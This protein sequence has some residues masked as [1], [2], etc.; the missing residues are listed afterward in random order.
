MSESARKRPAYKDLYKIPEN[1]TGEI[2][3][4]ELVVTPRP[5]RKH[6]YSTTALGAAVVPSYQFG[7]GGGLGGWVIIIEPEIGFGENIMV[8]DIAGWKED[9]YPEEEPHN[10]ISV[11]PDWICE[12]LSPN[13]LRVDKVRKMPIY[14]RHGVPYFWL[15][16]PAAETLDVFR[17]ASG[18][19]TLLGTYVEDDKVRAEPFGEIE[20]NLSDL[21]QGGRRKQ[22]AQAPKE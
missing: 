14:A 7:R 13:T 8:P 21:W 2:I 1:M 19:W 9:R 5:S 4:G 12:V 18:Q 10:W 17:L 11:V 22:A 6:G 3:N 16:D 15:I 20:I